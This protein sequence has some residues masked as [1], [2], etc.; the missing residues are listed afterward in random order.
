[1]C[2]IIILYISLNAIL[3]QKSNVGFIVNKIQTVLLVIFKTR[4]HI[5]FVYKNKIVCSQSVS[6]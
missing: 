2:I 3:T 5:A 6:L 4:L 1:M